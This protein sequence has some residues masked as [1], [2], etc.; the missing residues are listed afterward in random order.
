MKDL[1]PSFQ[2]DRKE[3][4]SFFLASSASQATSIQNNQYAI[5]A[6]LGAAHTEPQQV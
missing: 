5:S 4:Q 3:S 2:R 1:F 6:Y